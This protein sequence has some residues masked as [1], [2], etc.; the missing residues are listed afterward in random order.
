MADTAGD[1]YAELVKDQLS[2]QRARKASLEQRAVLVITS[3]GA[4]VTVVGALSAFVV[5]APIMAPTSA[6]LLLGLALLL[7]LVAAVLGIAVNWPRPYAEPAIEWMELLLQD[8]F[9]AGR[10][11]VGTSTSARAR[12]DTIRRAQTVNNTKAKCLTA[13]LALEVAAVGALCGMA[14]STMFMR[15][16]LR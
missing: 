10:W 14:F 11:S 1:A 4:L 8:T 5:K 13:A 2:E 16:S 6:K 7:F 3:S 15:S 12:L 9:W